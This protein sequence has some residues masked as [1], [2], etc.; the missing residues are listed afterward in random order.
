MGDGSFGS[1]SDETRMDASTTT[2]EASTERGAE[3]NAVQAV[4]RYCMLDARMHAKPRA[5]APSLRADV[6]MNRLKLAFIA[7][8]ARTALEPSTQDA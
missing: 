6:V 8:A 2:H 5:R 1:F 3:L 7:L 4:D